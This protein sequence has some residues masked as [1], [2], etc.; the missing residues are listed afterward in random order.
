MR[1]PHE[2]QLWE[3]RAKTK[4]PPP[5]RADLRVGCVDGTLIE[6][7]SLLLGRYE[8]GQAREVLR[9]STKVSPMCSTRGGCICDILRNWRCIRRSSARLNFFTSRTCAAKSRRPLT[10]KERR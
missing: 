6:R 1:P 4:L 5:E 3:R 9:Y 7:V 8:L 2:F 10:K